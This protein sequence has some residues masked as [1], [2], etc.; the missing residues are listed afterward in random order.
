LRSG[1]SVA[2]VKRFACE[3]LGRP[4]ARLPSNDP[5]LSGPPAQSNPF[6]EKGGFNLGAEVTVMTPFGPP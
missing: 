4:G 3:R 5:S 1:T 6:G 2:G